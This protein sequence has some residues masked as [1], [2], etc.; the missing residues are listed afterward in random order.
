MNKILLTGCNGTIGLELRPYLKR[1]DFKVYCWQ[2]D[3]IDSSNYQQMEG[4]IKNIQ[5]G[6]M[7]H[8]AA[9]TSFNEDNRKHAWQVNYEWPSELAWICRA[10]QIKFVFI[11]TN[12]VFGP[13]QQGP[14][15]PDSNAGAQQAY[16][17]EKKRAEERVLYQNPE[18]VIIRLGW[19]IA[20]Y[21]NNSMLTFL[22]KQDTI[23]ANTNWLPSCSFTSDTVKIIK[24]SLIYEAGTYMFNSNHRWNFYQIVTALKAKYH[25]SWSVIPVN[26][27]SKDERMIDKRIPDRPLSDHLEL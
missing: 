19:Q 20:N 25:K 24:E 6:A 14:F 9:I 1:N 4:F 12:M 13:H 23:H 11:S 3:K 5:P 2:K 15:Y 26:D 10:H 8:L 18:S 27:E 21:G 17:Y 7:I 22:D 16:G